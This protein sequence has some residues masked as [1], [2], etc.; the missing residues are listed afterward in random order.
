MGRKR[1]PQR[2]KLDDMAVRERLRRRHMT[3]NE[4]AALLGITPD[5]LSRLL[6]GTRHPSPRLRRQLQETLDCAGFEE[7]FVTVSADG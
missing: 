4:L 2:V 7:L 3:Q 1:S 6:N 5:Y